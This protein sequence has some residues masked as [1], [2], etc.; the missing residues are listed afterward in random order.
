MN[1]FVVVVVVVDTAAAVV[2][3]IVNFVVTFLLDLFMDGVL[4]IKILIVFSE[5]VVCVRMF[6]ELLAEIL[7][8][9]RVEFI[10][11]L[12]PFVLDNIGERPNVSVPF[13]QHLITN[14]TV[15]LHFFYHLPREYHWRTALN[16]LIEFISHVFQE[17]FALFKIPLVFDIVIIMCGWEVHVVSGIV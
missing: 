7:L 4:N 17:L 5:N 16:R 8:W 2:T 6:V 3:L 1:E 14:P 15:L 9:N 12:V 13:L 10:V 11:S